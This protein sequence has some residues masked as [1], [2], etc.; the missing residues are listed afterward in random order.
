M[1]RIEQSIDV[2]VPI[3]TAYNQW[4]QFEDF[5]RFMEGVTEVRQLD[6]AHLHWR[7]NR[8]GKETEWDSEIVDQQPDRHIAWRDISGPGNSG[9]VLFESE[10]EDKTRVTLIM[11]TDGQADPAIRQ[12]LEQ[13][14][15]RFKKLLESQ[16]HASGAW[17]GEIHDA[18][19]VP[20]NGSKGNPDSA[21]AAPP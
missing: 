8:H 9:Q 11:E 17:R 19:T 13:D 10:Q 15:A 4:T 5:P 2:N 21:D 18:Q 20:Q 1:E 6:D 3:H 16:G 7:A 14:L 12:R